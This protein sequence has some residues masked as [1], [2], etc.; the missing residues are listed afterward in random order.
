[1]GIVIASWFGMFYI[2][3]LCLINNKKDEKENKKK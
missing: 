3:A 2:L 1:M